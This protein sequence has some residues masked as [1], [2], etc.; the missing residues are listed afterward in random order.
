MTY[1]VLGRI[2]SYDG[3]LDEALR[4]QRRAMAHLERLAADDPET[5]V[6]RRRLGQSRD[7]HGPGPDRR[8]PAA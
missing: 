2:Q 1:E 7:G 5:G 4:S 8:G 6:Y 3:R